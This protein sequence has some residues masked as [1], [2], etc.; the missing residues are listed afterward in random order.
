MLCDWIEAVGVL[1]TT[2]VNVRVPDLTPVRADLRSD[3]AGDNLCECA[4]V[5]R[6]CA[7]ATRQASG[8]G[9]K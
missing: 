6:H 5:L 3:V 7:N 1:H 4:P 8:C 9:R 2:G